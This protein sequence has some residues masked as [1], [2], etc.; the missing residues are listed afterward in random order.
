V[1]KT[2]LEIAK[3]MIAVYGD[4]EAGEARR[5]LTDYARHHRVS[6]ADTAHALVSRTMDPIV[7]VGDPQ[8]S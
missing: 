4:I 1:A 3:A 6:L 5:R 2:A 7:I 8:G